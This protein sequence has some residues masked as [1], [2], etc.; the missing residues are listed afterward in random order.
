MAVILNIIINLYHTY[1]Y[2]K[3]KIKFKKFMIYIKVTVY[4]HNDHQSRS[5]KNIA[6]KSTD[7]I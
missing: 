3:T 7:E 1:K 2:S 6:M 5:N 4:T